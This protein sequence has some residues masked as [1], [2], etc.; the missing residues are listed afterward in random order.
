MTATVTVPVADGRARWRPRRTDLI[1]LGLWGGSRLVML[2]I[3]L[4]ALA[5]QPG[6][7]WLNLWQRWDWDRYLTIAQYGYT[8]GKGPA[9]DTNIVAFFPGYPGLLRA[10]DL[11]VRN[12]V[13]SG[14]LIS[15]VA[16]AVA[17]V[18]LARFTEYEWRARSG[19][20]N[21]GWVV[22]T[23]VLVLVTAPA[24]VF[25][26]AGYTESLFLALGIP[27]WLAARRR[28]WVLAG[29]L[30]ALACTVR[31]DGAFEAAGLAVMFLLGRP[32]VRDWARSPAL[33]LPLVAVGAYFAY[34][35]DITGDWLGWFH[36][37]A[38]G[39]SRRLTSPVTAF[40]TSW[41]NAFGSGPLAGGR[42]FG[43]RG[44]SA[45]VN[46]SRPGNHQ[47]LG[48]PNANP[49]TP[50]NPGGNFRRS[51]GFGQPGRGGSGA[52]SGPASSQGQGLGQ[53]QQAFSG[54]GLGGVGPFGPW[55]FRLDILMVLAGVVF[56]GWAA[57][58]R[59][60]AELTYVGLA[61]VAL[62]TSTYYMSVAREALLWWPLWIALAGWLSRRR[63]LT[64]LYLAASTA[65]MA[66]IT[67]LFLTGHWAG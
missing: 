67:W 26:A 40:R 25:L 41:A 61:V 2:F 45:N 5:A 56:L 34:L 59:R 23:S 27:A 47:N 7:S 19:T 8:S 4:A 17:C 55:P 31:I 60:W 64:G 18:A 53:G 62:A 10:V 39:W 12:W 32:R 65:M 28:Q 37:E 9:Y 38:N 3:S 58:R 50:N 49:N 48:N 35:K 14:L 36:A 20:G 22:A 6:T 33:A 44:R 15:L 54:H 46:P 1:A 30:T 11:V 57:F 66:G 29:V 51:S 42:G 24:A 63:W 43:G 13:V 21:P 16:G 52:G